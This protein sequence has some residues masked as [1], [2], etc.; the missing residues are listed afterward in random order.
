M[1]KPHQPTEPK[2]EKNVCGGSQCPITW[3]PCT[4]STSCHQIADSKFHCE[5]R[6]KQPGDNSIPKHWCELIAASKNRIKWAFITSLLS[7]GKEGWI[8]SA[9]IRPLN[10]CTD[11][12]VAP[13][14]NGQGKCSLAELQ[15][16]G[17][18]DLSGAPGWPQSPLCST[19]L[20]GSR[21][22]DTAEEAT[23]CCSSTKS[24]PGSSR[25]CPWVGY[26]A[27]QT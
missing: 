20:W 24:R 27:W 12:T 8:L 19:R 18:R 22:V 5:P 16:S 7:V 2:A 26:C 6:P 13:L 15:V 25:C 23:L 1:I 9:H 21:W 3:A 17:C 10:T 4:S 11:N 14:P